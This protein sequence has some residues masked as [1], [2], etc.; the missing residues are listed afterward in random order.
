MRVQYSK[1]QI[2]FHF[3][4][5]MS[6]PTTDRLE[7]MALQNLL[8]VSMWTLIKEQK[9]SKSQYELRL[10][11]MKRYRELTG[12]DYVYQAVREEFQD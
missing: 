10:E 1:H 2:V 7:V 8:D 4:V 6:R 9:E 11:R 5:S 3:L 12:E